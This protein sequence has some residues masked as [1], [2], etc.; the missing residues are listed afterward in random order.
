M[1]RIHQ[2]HIDGPGLMDGARDHAPGDLVEGDAPGLLLRQ[3]HKLAQMPGDGLSLAVR[4]GGEIDGV[5]VLRRVLELVH[6]GLFSLDLDIMGL[7]VVLDIHAEGALGQIPQMA[8]TRLDDIIA[9]QIF[10]DRLRFGRR[11]Y[12]H[13]I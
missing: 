4:V 1:L 12:D 2:V 5:A 8:H 7:E 3:L 10:S 6:Q 9:P 13:K 11:L